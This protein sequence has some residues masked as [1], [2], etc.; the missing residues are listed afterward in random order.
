MMA[1]SLDGFNIPSRC[2]PDSRSS[3]E[4]YSQGYYMGD[5]EGLKLFRSKE[6][7]HR[8]SWISVRAFRGLTLF[9]CSRRASR[10]GESS[11]SIVFGLRSCLPDPGARM[12]VLG[13]G[14][15]LSACFVRSL[16]ALT[17]VLQTSAFERIP[18]ATRSIPQ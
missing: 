18:V 5:L 7:L 2:V 16:A 14:S 17:V 8:R 13:A 3:Y 11:K 9:V 6:L 4:G 12:Q 10:P 1:A 15:S